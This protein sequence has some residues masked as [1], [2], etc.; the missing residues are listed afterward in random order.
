MRKAGHD[1]FDAYLNHMTDAATQVRT[2][3][4]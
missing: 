3:L 1:K 4:D 2:I